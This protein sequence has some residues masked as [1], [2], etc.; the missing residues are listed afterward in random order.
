[1]EYLVKNGMTIQL[2][3]VTFWDANGVFIAQKE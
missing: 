1:V 3:V 2:H